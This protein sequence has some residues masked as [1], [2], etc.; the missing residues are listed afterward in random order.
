MD[1][2]R[3]RIS[4]LSRREKPQV[5]LIS[6]Y[7]KHLPTLFLSGPFLLSTG[8][9]LATVPP[10]EIEDWILPNSYL[11]LVISLWCGLFFLTTFAFLKTRRGAA[12]STFITVLVW[13]R[14]QSF[15]LDLGMIGV[16]A[17]SL[18][19]PLLILEILERKART[20]Q[21]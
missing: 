9:I 11:P 4:T 14:L 18:F 13:L 7:L 16:V 12:V 6:R 20:W 17:S 19:I 3:S 21:H 1:R 15:Q 8:I 5:S 2:A 10:A